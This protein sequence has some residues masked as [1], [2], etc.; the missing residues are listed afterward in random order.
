MQ[1]IAVSKLSLFIAIKI[2]MDHFL[3]FLETAQP[4]MTSIHHSIY[5]Y[6]SP[7]AGEHR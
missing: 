6:P 1:I 5:A 3:A 7:F 4:I 2:N